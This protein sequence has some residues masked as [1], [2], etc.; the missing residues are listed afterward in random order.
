MFN[1]IVHKQ[2]DKVRKEKADKIVAGLKEEYKQRLKKQAEEENTIK[3]SPSDINLDDDEPSDNRL[4]PEITS[5][6]KNTVTFDE[7]PGDSK[8]KLQN[9]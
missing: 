7:N 9:F 2:V 5:P 6:S 1:N 3:M 8:F 4:F